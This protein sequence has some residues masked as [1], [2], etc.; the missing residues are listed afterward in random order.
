MPTMP[1]DRSRPT[2]ARGFALLDLILV[3]TILGIVTAVAVQMSSTDGLRV[4]VAARGIAADLAEA[5]S[6]A[7][8]TRQPCGILFDTARNRYAFAGDDGALL[9]VSEG[10]LR[11]KVGLAAVDVDRLVA[12]ETA[13][14]RGLAPVT[15]TAA[16][17]GGSS[18]I[19]FD[20]D[21]VPRASG[22]AEVA[23]GTAVLRIRVQ[24]PAGRITITAP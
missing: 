5:Q 15:L 17:F 12:A 1:P 3:V 9:S 6:M 18:L 24:A 16:T 21:G 22:Y 19:L 14:E 7:I 10:V 23:L 11:V 2:G 13:G 20:P 4:D 8:Q